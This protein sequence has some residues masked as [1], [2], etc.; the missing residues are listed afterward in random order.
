VVWEISKLTKAETN[1]SKT[2]K[3]KITM[4][5]RLKRIEKFTKAMRE[6]LAKMLEDPDS[7]SNIYK[8]I[9]GAYTA[10]MNSLLE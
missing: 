1:S 6:L 5:E 2:I 10:G 3:R 4:E 8:E 7:S 9:W